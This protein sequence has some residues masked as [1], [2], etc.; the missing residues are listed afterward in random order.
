MK[1]RY[2]A[3]ACLG[4]KF[5]GMFLYASDLNQIAGNNASR[6]SQNGISLLSCNQNIIRDNVVDE[7]AA[8][9]I[10]LNLSHDNQV[11][12]NNI[13]SNP[14]GLQVMLSTGNKIF[15]NNFLGNQEHSQDIGGNNSW[16]DGNVT[17]G[18]YWRVT[19]PKAIPARIGQG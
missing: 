7:N 19:W 15:H 11:Y 2:Q 4:N 9:G 5:S 10:W 6:N 17:G 16:D 8:T 3:I 18:N 13:S 14:L 12:Q 1:M